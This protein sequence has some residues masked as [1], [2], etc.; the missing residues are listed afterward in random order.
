MEKEDENHSKRQR[1]KNTREKNRTEQRKKTSRAER[2]R[3][4]KEIQREKPFVDRGEGL[5]D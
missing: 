1:R 3:V 4:T 2:W 5:R